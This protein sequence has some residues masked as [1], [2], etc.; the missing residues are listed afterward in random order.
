MQA[1][2]FEKNVQ[3]KM[4]ELQLYPSAGVWSEVEK[5]IRRQ[6]RRRRIIFWWLFPLLLAVG[7]MTAYLLTKENGNKH[8]Q[9]LQTHTTPAGN[10]KNNNNTE[11]KTQLQQQ[12]QPEITTKEKDEPSSSD[13]VAIQNK[14]VVTG[15]ISTESKTNA[16]KLPPVKDG[17][18]SFEN[19]NPG[20][21]KRT[22]QAKK[23]EKADLTSNKPVTTDIN[24]KLPSPP[25][26]MVAMQQKDEVK[27]EI[28]QPVTTVQ[29][30]IENKSDSAI[31]ADKKTTTLP[32]ADT[33]TKKQPETVQKKKKDKKSNWEFGITAAS[34]ISG[35]VDGFSLFPENK[36]ADALQNGGGVNAPV[37]DSL[38]GKSSN[39]FY[40]MAGG[41][42]KKMIGKK[43]AVSIGLNFS[44]Y[45]VRQ[46]TGSYVDSA[47][48]ISAG[49]FTTNASGYYRTGGGAVHNNRYYFASLPFTLHW[50]LNK[51]KKMPLVW[52]HSI[53]PMFLLG[54]NA[55]VYNNPG[56]VYYKDN[57]IFR[58]LQFAY[59]SGIYGQFGKGAKHPISAGLFFN[60]HLGQLQ[61]VE[62]DNK[63]HLLSFGIQVNWTLKK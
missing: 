42:A 27:K 37:P 52:Q 1:N 5:K 38:P 9:S 7:S 49:E 28:V 45:T 4:D 29:S 19:N 13:P 14:K 10:N 11:T 58:K 33:A 35:R 34:G 3:H 46:Q 59:Q 51:G 24:D 41:Y 36:N 55:L 21:N 12:Q 30:V 63:N 61:K 25:A 44:M 8:D 60:Y 53:S 6:K 31:A 62:S 20:K 56:N 39:G 40:A 16:Y 15:Y 50:Q 18:V 23:N 57:N 26:A 17:N 22:K 48:L 32:P 47:R 2:E 54:S 43:T